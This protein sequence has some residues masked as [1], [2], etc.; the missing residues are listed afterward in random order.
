MQNIHPYDI[1]SY[2]R[3][4]LVSN[5]YVIFGNFRGSFMEGDP[6]FN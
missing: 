2:D 4:Q 5:T 1:H 6:Q 3:F